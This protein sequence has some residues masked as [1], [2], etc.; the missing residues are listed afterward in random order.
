MQNLINPIQQPR[1]YVG[2]AMRKPI[3]REY[4]VLVQ[5][6]A[7]LFTA[8]VVEVVS[9]LKKS[10]LYKRTMKQAVN[11]TA[12]ELKLY[13]KYFN[14]RLVDPK[15]FADLAGLIEDELENDMQLLRIA[16]KNTLDKRQVEY[17]DIYTQLEYTV[18]LGCMSI[19]ITDRVSKDFNARVKDI[20]PTKLVTA[21]G[22]VAEAM[23]KT[24]GYGVDLRV[25]ED[26]VA[27]IV[28]LSNKMCSGEMFFKL[29][30]KV[31][32]E[33]DGRVCNS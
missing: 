13:S 2:Y 10:T 29:I 30:N 22:K 33:Y 3:R 26:I 16:I 15:A 6:M 17:S 1:N 32:D 31:A 20:R 9:M 11:A 28:R 8:Q 5:A 12:K 27:F 18:T 4:E 25:D 19:A 24:A 23:R 14:S 7:D 21:L